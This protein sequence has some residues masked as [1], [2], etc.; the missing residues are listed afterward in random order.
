MLHN[1]AILLKEPL[2]QEEEPAQD[3][4]GD[5]DGGHQPAED[6]RRTRDFITRKFFS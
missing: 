4:A 2:P 1:I 3:D 5:I 6:G